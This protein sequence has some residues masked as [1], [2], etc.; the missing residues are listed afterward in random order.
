MASEKGKADRS[1]APV[2][3]KPLAGLA[4]SLY[5]PLIYGILL[6]L[7]LCV[8][9]IVPGLV[10]YGT[11]VEFD[12]RPEGAAVYVD[13]IR[14]GATPLVAFVPAGEH[15]VELR[16]PYFATEEG[17]VTIA[18]R[19]IASL[20]FPR[21]QRYFSSL[22]LDD[23]DGL[24]EA[25]ASDF[26]A[27][28][29]IGRATN[30]YQFAPTLTDSVRDLLSAGSFDSITALLE[31]SLPDVAS[32]ALLRDFL[33]AYTL[34][35]SSGMAAGPN[36]LIRLFAEILSAAERYEGLPFFMLA[37]LPAEMAEKLRQ[38]NWFADF[39]DTYITNLL[40]TT[41]ESPLADDTAAVSAIS[42]IPF[43]TI[44]SGEFVMGSLMGEPD[45][46]VLLLPHV[47]SVP[48]LFVGQTEVTQVQF[49]RFLE[50]RPEWDIDRR[51]ELIGRGVATEDYLA[52]WDPRNPVA[53]LPAG[54]I[55]W[56]AAQAF[57]EW[58][59][60]QLPA[61]LVGYRVRLPSEREWEWIAYYTSAA[62]YPAA[63][64]PAVDRLQRVATSGIPALPVYDL[65]GNLWEWNNNW[66]HP[67]QYS[68]RN[69]R[70][71]TA[72]P[73]R[74]AAL[75]GAARALRGGSW[76]EERR[77]VGIETRGSLPPHWASPHVG[78]RLVLVEE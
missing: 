58:L 33:K 68:V 54:S 77:T 52:D 69:R 71:E 19:R 43:V 60:E 12:S 15:R 13:G 38:S 31:N 67:L 16:R 53:G 1:G 27:W 65:L 40:P 57:A 4:P 20:F 49:A 10:R 22:Q 59:Q 64:R 76:I 28:A 62:A 34:S 6:L 36:V 5:V 66:Y 48:A 73:T 21:R 23:T 74:K 2:A 50:A 25:A 26:A 42:G 78:F 63:L 9:L 45:I 11:V 37:A 30:Q 3:L 75:P 51:A 61:S 17:N 46:D 56:F 70:G 72:Q 35:H 44:P 55:S 7:L 29:L 8:L 47:V 14:I 41:H 18:G 39:E 24:V 32:E